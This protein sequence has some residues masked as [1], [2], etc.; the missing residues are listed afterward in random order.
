MDQNGKEAFIKKEMGACVVPG[1][2]FVAVTTPQGSNEV[3]L[4]TGNY[5]TIGRGSD[6]ILVFDDNAMSRRHAVIQRMDG[7]D[8]SQNERQTDLRAL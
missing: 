1:R 5:W 8:E 3:S 2:A 6:N 7:G 4:D